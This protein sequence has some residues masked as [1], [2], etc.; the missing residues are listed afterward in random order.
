MRDC[1]RQGHRAADGRVHPRC[2]RRNH[3]ADAAAGDRGALEAEVQQA[4]PLAGLQAAVFPQKHHPGPDGLYEDHPAADIDLF[5]PAGHGFRLSP[6]SLRRY[7]RLDKAYPGIHLF[8]AAQ[9]GPG[10]SGAG[11][12]GFYLP[13]VGL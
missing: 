2:G 9:G 8:H 1:G 3:G 12:G 13:V 10:L 7:Q 6:V 4:Q 5:Q 11:R